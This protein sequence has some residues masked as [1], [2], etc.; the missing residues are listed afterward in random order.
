MGHY[1]GTATG[2]SFIL[3]GVTSPPINL[4]VVC[5]ASSS[6]PGAS[7]EVRFAGGTLTATANGNTMTG[8]TVDTWNEF[9]AN[10]QTKVATMV[11]SYSFTVTKTM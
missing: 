2:A 7:H 5:D 6:Q 3:P 10:T 8:T 9:V 1:I 11:V 4:F